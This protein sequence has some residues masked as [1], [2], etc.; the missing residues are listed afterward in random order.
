MSI[1]RSRRRVGFTLIELLVV[2]A[3]IAIL[4]GLLLPAVQKVRE[5]AARM[6]C[7][8]NLKQLGIAL[9]SN[10]DANQKFPMGSSRGTPGGGAWGVS[11]K[12]LILPYIEQDNL[13]RQIPLTSN[14]HNNGAINAVAQITTIK[15]Y[16]CPSSTVPAFHTGGNRQMITSYMGISGSTLTPCSVSSGNGNVSGGGMLFPNSEVTMTGITDGTS[17]TIM[18]GEQSDHLRDANN[19]PIPGG[20]AIT[21]QGV[22]GWTMGN[23]DDTR[24]PPVFQNGGDNRSFNNTTTRFMINQR[25]IGSSGANGTN[26]DLG[27]NIPMSSAHTGGVNCVFAD[28]SVRFLTSSTPLVTLQNLSDIADGFVVTLP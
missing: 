7:Q 13:F 14:S 21:S 27:N 20:S 17:N 15:T 22:W 8:N 25:G 10:H 19:Q 1:L 6:S 9:H 11:W 28:G 26:E 16:R 18:V 12:V 3:I 5:A 24:L 23:T 4:I 2:I